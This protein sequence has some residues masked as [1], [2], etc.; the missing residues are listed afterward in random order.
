MILLRE[1]SYT[2]CDKRQNEGFAGFT[3]HTVPN[4]DPRLH[5]WNMVETPRNQTK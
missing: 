5:L 1:K 3:K 2:G 4:S